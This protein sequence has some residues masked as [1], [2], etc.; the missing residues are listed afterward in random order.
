MQ[1]YSEGYSDAS[2]NAVLSFTHAKRERNTYSSDLGKRKI[3][4][5]N[6]YSRVESREREKEREM[7]RCPPEFDDQMQEEEEE[8]IMATYADAAKWPACPALHPW[9]SEAHAR[10]R[11]LLERQKHENR[12][13]FDAQMTIAC[14]PPEDPN[15]T[16]S[17]YYSTIRRM[18]Q[19]PVGCFLPRRAADT[20]DR[21]IKHGWDCWDDWADDYR[22][23]LTTAGRAACP[24][25][26]PSS[27]AP[28]ALGALPSRNELWNQVT[29]PGSQ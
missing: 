25:A 7:S 17:A 12:R 14:P 6:K 18:P 2:L 9:S 23:S 29:R 8:S 11:Q 24:G 15:D 26:D 16:S 1:V 28:A 19:T 21:N 5:P 4:S 13:L 20:C 22:P 10:H 3:N 27:Y